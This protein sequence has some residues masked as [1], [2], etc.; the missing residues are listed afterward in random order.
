MGKTFVVLR[1]KRGVNGYLSMKIAPMDCWYE[2]SFVQT[3]N[4][5]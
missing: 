1:N 2:D 5:F 3:V 4:F